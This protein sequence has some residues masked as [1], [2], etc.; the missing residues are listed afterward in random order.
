MTKTLNNNL[1][2]KFQDFI[3]KNSKIDFLLAAQVSDREYLSLPWL[4][5]IV[6]LC[7]RFNYSVVK[8]FTNSLHFYLN[9]Q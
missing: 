1:T 4:H 8:L 5:T 6:L 9:I 3:E 7:C 2:R